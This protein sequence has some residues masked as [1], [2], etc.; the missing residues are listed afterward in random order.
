MIKTFDILLELENKSKNLP[1]SVSQ[2]D[3]NAIQLNM[4]I[5][6]DGIPLNIAGTTSARI[7]I[8]KPGGLSVIQD[9]EIV[10]SYKGKISVILSTQ[11]YAEIGK[12]D[13][14][15]YLYEG[16]VVSVTS[17]F[18]Y[19][20][21]KAI[22]DNGTV[23]STNDWQSINDA[24]IQIDGNINRIE[25]ADVYTK[26]EADVKLT[27]KV[28]VVAGKSLS[29]NDYDN[30]EKSEVA[31]VKN[32]ADTSY[33]DNGLLTKV[34]KVAGKGLSTNDYDNAEKSE[35]AKVKDK[36]DKAYVDTQLADKAKQT[37]LNT[38]NANVANNTS[39]I[40]S[41]TVNAK[42]P[43]N[44]L[45]AAVGN[46][47]VDDTAALQALINYCTT[48]KRNLYLPAGTYK[49][50]SA[51]SVPAVQGFQLRG[52]S[53]RGTTLDPQHNDYAI[54]LVSGSQSYVFKDFSI[55]P[56][57]AT[58][59]Y[60]YN[61]INIKDALLCTVDNVCMFYP[62]IGLTFEGATYVCTTKML[63]IYQFA[64]KGI[65]LKSNG[66]SVPNG[67]RIS[68][69]FVRG[70]SQST[71]NSYGVYIEDG[72][73]N[74]FT[75]GQ[76]S[77]CDTAIYQVNGSRN[78][79]EKFWL[80]HL[81][82]SINILAGTAIVDCHGAFLN[83][84]ASGARLFNNSG[85]STPFQ[86]LTVDKP[87]E[88]KNLK[89][90]WMFNEGSG[91]RVLDKSGNKKHATL[92]GTPTWTTDGTWGTAAY[93]K[94]SDGRTITIPTNTVDWTQ[95]YTYM[96]NHSLIAGATPPATGLYM[97]DGVGNYFMAGATKT[98]L[99]G[100]SF[101][102]GV[103]EVPAFVGVGRYGQ[104]LTGKNIYSFV[105]VD[106]I[107]KT[108]E[109]IDPFSHVNP[110]LQMTN[111]FT[112][113]NPTSVH[114]SGRAHVSNT[115]EGNMS[116]AAFW[117]RKL[118]RDEVFDIVNTNGRPLSSFDKNVQLGTTLVSPNGSNYKITVNDSGVLTAT[119]I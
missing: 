30:T 9:C 84:V 119:L 95:P 29:T 88:D 65:Y 82:T 56:Q 48:N 73:V 105:Y 14:E 45:T 21:K 46:G 44:S 116:M 92:N 77:D 38:T 54:S 18:S 42:Y 39:Q 69:Q 11:A 49:T 86:D 101:I 104:P 66:G 118:S 76:I 3:L 102:G 63:Y 68:I 28:N 100:Q 89:A 32:K 97:F 87:K 6:K 23:T 2:N 109:V 74:T 107:N 52:D 61:G 53:N 110:V 58:Y 85:E 71:P 103:L 35:V 78:Y 91:S 24:L 90:L 51:L 93:F 31:K 25:N 114:I 15:I 17:T 113:A 41:L 50:T 22:L 27:G 1:F 8:K 111:N 81:N 33:V 10:D 83:Q 20:S 64:E 13:A 80:E 36:A 117:Q 5:L 26:S 62:R 57:N 96:I 7:A 4:T 19:T 98:V 79:Y 99:I 70:I 47:V 112:I 16:N 94:Y 34:D 55:N 72:K 43:P 115:N 75:D 37:D 60:A 59:K 67:N 40:A 108:I 106:P 12:H